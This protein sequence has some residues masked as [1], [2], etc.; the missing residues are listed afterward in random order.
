M[1]QESTRECRPYRDCKCLST[2]YVGIYTCTENFAEYVLSMYKHEFELHPLIPPSLFSQ[3]VYNWI[4]RTAKDTTFFFII[5]IHYFYSQKLLT[6]IGKLRKYFYNNKKICRKL[7]VLWKLFL[8]LSLEVE[9][10]YLD[11]KMAIMIFYLFKC[12]WCCSILKTTGHIELWFVEDIIVDASIVYEL[13][14]HF[15][16]II[17]CVYPS[18]QI[19]IIRYYK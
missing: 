16:K 8:S 19:L 2:N 6:E 18:N 7:W 17:I 1:E 10:M 12:L 5:F 3:N 14:D 4:N 9:L 15:F 11:I 13:T